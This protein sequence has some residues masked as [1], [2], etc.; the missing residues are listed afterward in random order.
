MKFLFRYLVAFGLI[1]TCLLPSLSAQTQFEIQYSAFGNTY[2]KDMLIAPDGGYYLLIQA[3]PS[4]GEEWGPVLV[5]LDAM[6][7]EQWQRKYVA[8][9]SQYESIDEMRYDPDGNIVLSGTF[10]RILK[11]D[12][13]GNI[14]WAKQVPGIGLTNHRVEGLAIAANGDIALALHYF[15][16]APRIMR[17][18]ENGDAVWIRGYTLPRA[19][20]YAEDLDYV[21]GGGFVM[22][23]ET[24]M[25]AR[26]A[27]DGTGLWLS[28]IRAGVESYLEA[29]LIE[30]DNSI[31]TV[32]GARNSFGDPWNV[33]LIRT[34]A[35]GSHGW[36][37]RYGTSADLIG[38]DL[39]HTPDGGYLLMAS[40][41]TG[42]ALI[43]TDSLG[44][45]E[46]NTYGSQVEFDSPK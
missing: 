29:S 33:H 35:D 43:K 8:M 21:P 2:G 9:A 40:F 41:S 39:L 25:I 20:G 24:G 44:T 4:S 18:D 42:V 34:N 38:H 30:S 31:T 16:S 11:L 45:P 26:I 17:F 10:N 5:K 12:T 23:H 7:N 36:I 22:T 15:G 6:G 19:A 37:R 46:W 3:H 14:I 1:S 13:L 27:D 32:G 28:D